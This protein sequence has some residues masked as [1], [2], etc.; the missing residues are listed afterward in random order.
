M[1]AG[2]ACVG[3]GFSVAR[4]THGPFNWLC[5]SLKFPLARF[6]HLA[7]Q[8]LKARTHICAHWVL[9]LYSPRSFLVCLSVLFILTNAY[10][11]RP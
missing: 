11:D 3:L 6:V 5:V 2:C 1:G 8:S 9:D 10:P 4:S 7:T